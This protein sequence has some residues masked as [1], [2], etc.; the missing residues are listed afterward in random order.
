M[1]VMGVR[2]L[3]SEKDHPRLVTLENNR[4]NVGGEYARR[5]NEERIRAIKC[6]TDNSNKQCLLLS[7]EFSF[8]QYSRMES[9]STGDD[10]ELS[11]REVWCS[12]FGEVRL[13]MTE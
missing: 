9:N 6:A 8:S 1:C 4:M 3:P 7:T 5:L 12:S 10:L 13:G 11:M 2:S